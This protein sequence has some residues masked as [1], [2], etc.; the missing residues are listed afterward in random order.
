MAEAIPKQG[1]KKKRARK[2]KVVEVS[3][4]V[5]VA[6]LEVP[7]K[8]TRKRTMPS[9]TV[10][11]VVPDASSGRVALPSRPKKH[12]KMR[13]SPCPSHLSEA[14]T[15]SIQE[16]IVSQQAE[17]T[18]PLVVKAEARP[19]ERLVEPEIVQP[20]TLSPLSQ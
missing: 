2:N 13:A 10:P 5:V 15:P 11:L 3:E 1:S 18:P 4:P 12:T 8:S 20:L 7:R 6:A 19:A 9:P 14:A 16:T 17:S